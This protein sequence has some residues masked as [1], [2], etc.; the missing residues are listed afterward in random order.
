MTNDTPLSLPESFCWYMQA[1]NMTALERLKEQKTPPPGLDWNEV[2]QFYRSQYAYTVIQFDYYLF[3]REAWERVWGEALGEALQQKEAFT[4]FSAGEYAVYNVSPAPEDVWEDRLVRAYHGKE[5]ET[6]WFGIAVDEE[7]EALCL[8][9]HR[10]RGEENLS[11]NMALDPEIWEA[12]S[13]AD[14]YRMT[15]KALC[16]LTT[17]LPPLPLS[18]E[19]LRRAAGLVL[20]AQAV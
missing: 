20:K 3:L 9:W 7:Y 11:G 1:E 8:Y 17:G 15:K 18:L 6:W 4:P 10:G 16:R 2:E 19:K 5:G 14:G 13:D 12:A